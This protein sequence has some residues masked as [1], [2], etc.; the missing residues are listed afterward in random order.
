[1]N[2]AKGYDWRGQRD[3]ARFCRLA[4]AEGLS[5]ILRPG[6]YACAEW[7]MGGL[8]WWLLKQPGDNFLRTRDPRFA[9]P[10]RR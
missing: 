6:P 4:Q 2:G 5:V 9:Q 8:P 10:A 1:M 7:E 3:A